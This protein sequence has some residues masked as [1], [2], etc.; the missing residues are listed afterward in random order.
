M[1]TILGKRRRHARRRQLHM[2]YSRPLSGNVVQVVIKRPG[3]PAE[4]GAQRLRQE[5]EAPEVRDTDEQELAADIEAK[6]QVVRIC[7]S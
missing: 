2:T 3:P 5:C 1:E 7:L 6:A 4:H